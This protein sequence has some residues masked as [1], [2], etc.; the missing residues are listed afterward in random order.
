MSECTDEN[1]PACKMAGLVEEL[2][3]LGFT[4]DDIFGLTAMCTEVIYG[5]DIE[6]IDDSAGEKRI[7][8]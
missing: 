3:A 2:K 8:H 1:C 6:V 7:V 4:P 5:I